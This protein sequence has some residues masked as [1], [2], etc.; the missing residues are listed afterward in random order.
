MGPR[1]IVGTILVLVGVVVMTTAPVKKPE[2]GAWAGEPQE[3][4]P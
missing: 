2:T 4:E 1:T 3:A